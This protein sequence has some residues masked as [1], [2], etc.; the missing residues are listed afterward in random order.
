MHTFES[1]SFL[2]AAPMELRQYFFNSIHAFCMFEMQHLGE[3]KIAL[4]V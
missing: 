1:H 2:K 4:N 3:A